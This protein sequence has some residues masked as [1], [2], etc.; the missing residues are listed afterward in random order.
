MIGFVRDRLRW[1]FYRGA[2]VLSLSIFFRN[3]HNPEEYLNRL[4]LDAQKQL[5]DARRVTAGAVAEEKHL[6]LRLEDQQRL[7][8]RYEENARHALTGGDEETARGEMHHWSR[9]RDYVRALEQELAR[10]RASVEELRVGLHTLQGRIEDAQRRKTVIF[11]RLRDPLQR[12]QLHRT[13]REF[14]SNSS[15]DLF[16][17]LEEQTRPLPDRDPE[18][19]VQALTDLT[20]EEMLEELRRALPEREGQ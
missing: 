3:R 12:E 16:V 1:V 10:R 20:A 19:E 17:L 8:S 5:A 6:L 15:L 11:A 14:S 18:R 13:I 4:L 9:E 7:V 2:R